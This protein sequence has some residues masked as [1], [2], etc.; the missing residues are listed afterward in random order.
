MFLTSDY[1]MNE[2]FFYTHTFGREAGRR[3]RRQ[4]GQVSHRTDTY[5]QSFTLTF[6]T[7]DNLKSPF[8]RSYMAGDCRR[9]VEHPEETHTD[10]GKTRHRKAPAG[11]LR[12]ELRCKKDITED[13]CNRLM[14]SKAPT[15]HISHDIYVSMQL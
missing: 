5:C 11:Q 1:H 7:M 8:H 3:P 12:F 9:E 13:T 4:T 15:N 10:S 14:S 2:L 6:T